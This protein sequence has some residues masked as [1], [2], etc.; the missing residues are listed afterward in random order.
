MVAVVVVIV[1]VVVVVV[2]DVVEVEVVVVVVVVYPKAISA[3][4]SSVVVARQAPHQHNDAKAERP[5]EEICA[6]RYDVSTK[7]C[8]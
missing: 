6:T 1:V 4:F 2:V 7:L 8:H 3:A 5:Q